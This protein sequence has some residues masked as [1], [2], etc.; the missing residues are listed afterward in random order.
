MSSLT[1]AAIVFACIFSGSLF[2]IWL[3]YRLP[4][5]H[6]SP[7]SRDAVKLATGMLSVL[8]AL[9]LGLLIASVKN[10]FDNT[11]SQIRQ[12]A[13]TLILLNQ[14]LADYGP[15]TIEARQLLRRYT[16]RALED[17]WPEAGDKP[18]R[19]EDVKSGT[20]LDGVRTAILTL[21]GGDTRRDAL[22][23][24]TASLVEDALKTR[25]LLIERTGS[26][27]QNMFMEILIV[28]VTLIFVSFGYNA[29]RNATI[30]TT[31]MVAAAALA[32]CIFLIVE[33]DG[34]FDGL[35]TVSSTPMRD[36]LTHMNP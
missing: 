26:S 19:M 4:E 10:S 16:A 24:D 21:P 25:W 20:L 7:E 5:H 6:R 15:E 11:D 22:R 2:G 29:P 12:F 30:L 31:F 9:V 35:I 34:P 8:A 18:V 33:M 14:T 13:A 3:N 28:W 1:I 23:A 36:A 17:N 32:G 27:I